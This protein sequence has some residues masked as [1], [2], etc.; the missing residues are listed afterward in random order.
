MH[1]IHRAIQLKTGVLIVGKTEAELNSGMVSILN[2]IDPRH[3]ISIFEEVKEIKLQDLKSAMSNRNCSS[4]LISQSI[5][6]QSIKQDAEC[7]VVPR[8]TKGTCLETV[9]KSLANKESAVIIGMKA[10]GIDEAITKI[11]EMTEDVERYMIN[12]PYL[13]RLEEDKLY[14]FKI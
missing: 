7:L 3:K 9:L 2:G 11:K 10:N 4:H 13:Y 5:Q 14:R 12:I 6:A 1:E 8:I